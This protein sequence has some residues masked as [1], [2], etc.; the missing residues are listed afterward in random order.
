MSFFYD[1]A[2]LLRVP[3]G[4]VV[5]TGELGRQLFI[6]VLFIELMLII[7]IVPALTA[8]AITTERERKLMICCKPR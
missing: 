2:H 8:G 4:G 5:V 3:Q 7:F 1:H 6:G